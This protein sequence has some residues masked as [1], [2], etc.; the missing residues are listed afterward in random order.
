M[1][2]NIKKAVVF[3][4]SGLV[5]KSLVAQLLA[6][7]AVT[8]V[9]LIVRQPIFGLNE[10]KKLNVVVVDDLLKF[11]FESSTEVSHIFSC[12]GTT[13][14]KA[15]SRQRFYQVDY[16]INAHLANLAKQKHA[17]FLLVSAIGA[18]PKAFSFYSRVKGELEQ[19]V[20]Q[21][22]LTK[23]SIIRPSLLLGERS[24]TRFLE[25]IAQKLYQ[26]IHRLSSRAFLYRPVQAQQVAYTM[27][28]AAKNQTRTIEIY[29]NLK[30]QQYINEGG[31]CAVN[32]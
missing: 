10:Q 15:G 31:V 26:K 11:N 13:L 3:G 28:E 23:L 19:Y 16:Q 5:G 7:S 29:D 4:A 27:V 2:K 6:D 9:T 14:K 1:T 21:Q 22:D 32:L 12:I 24:E 18:N 8:E 25:D 30:I 17:H 20:Q